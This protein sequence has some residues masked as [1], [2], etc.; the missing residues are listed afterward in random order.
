M[1]Q[2]GGN[3]S[4]KINVHQDDKGGWVRIF[5]DHNGPLP[6]DF[7]FGMSGILNEWFRQR[8][9]LRMR[10]V[11]PINRDGDTVELHAWYDVVLFPTVVQK[12]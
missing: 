10:C 7:G 1:K 9:H 6:P 12:T 8:P 5:T 4:G 3:G 11:V 2:K